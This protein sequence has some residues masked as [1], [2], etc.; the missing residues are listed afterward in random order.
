MNPGDLQDDIDMNKGL[1]QHTEQEIVDHFY[2]AKSTI[3]CASAVFPVRDKKT[4][5]WFPI[6]LLFDQDRK[7]FS[8]AFRLSNDA[9]LEAL[10]GL[11]LGVREECARRNGGATA[12]SSKGT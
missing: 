5:K 10:I 7:A 11:L 3:E 12:P 8:Y 1:Y 4:G 2:R 9:Q 6:L